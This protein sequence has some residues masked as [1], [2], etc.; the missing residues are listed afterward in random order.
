VC[1]CVCVCVCVPLNA[2]KRT[3]AQCARVLD[4]VCLHGT[5]LTYA[6]AH[7]QTPFKQFEVFR[8]ISGGHYNSADNA[9]V[10]HVSLR[11]LG[12]CF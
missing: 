6:Q 5:C 8:F 7:A 3:D 12:G 4:R 2:R 1:V 11:V 10:V 9:F